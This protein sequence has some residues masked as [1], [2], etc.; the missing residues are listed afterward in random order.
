MFQWI[1]RLFRMGQEQVIHIHVHIHT[2]EDELDLDRKK[3]QE[4]SHVADRTSRKLKHAIRCASGALTNES[5]TAPTVDHN[6]VLKEAAMSAEMDHAVERVR[7]LET[8][9][10]GAITLMTTLSGMIRDTAGDRNAALAL[11]DEVDAKATALA[12]AITANTPA[13]PTPVATTKKK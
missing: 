6:P 5:T 2:N 12:D 10:E 13:S 8:V 4:I 3:A 7:N 11:A 1:R 9:S